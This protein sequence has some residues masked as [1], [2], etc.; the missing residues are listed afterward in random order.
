MKHFRS[1]S[2]GLI[3]KLLTQA[4][5]DHYKKDTVDYENLSVHVA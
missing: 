3:G 5:F 4:G 2:V 1:S